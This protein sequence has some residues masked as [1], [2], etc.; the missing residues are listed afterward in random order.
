MFIDDVAIVT[1]LVINGLI[2]GGAFEVYEVV[3]SVYKVFSVCEVF[4]VCKVSVVCEVFMVCV[5]F[6]AGTFG[7]NCMAIN[8]ELISSDETKLKWAV[9]FGIVY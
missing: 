3:F 4:T 8:T 9:A 7:V 5:V 1:C 2:I 6:V